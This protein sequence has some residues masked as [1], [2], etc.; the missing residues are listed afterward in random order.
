MNLF[1]HHLKHPLI[2]A[3]IV[4]HIGWRHEP[5]QLMGISHFLEHVHYLGSKHYPDIDA[6]T[7]R[8]GTEINGPTLPESTAFSF[9]VL[10]EDFFYVLPVLLDIVYFPRFDSESIERERNIVDVPGNPSDYMAWEWVRLK[11]DDMVFNTNELHSLGTEK[12]IQAIQREDLVKWQNDFYHTGN[13]HLL[14]A[15]DVET[16]EVQ[17]LLTKVQLPSSGKRPKIVKYEHQKQH[18]QE[19]RS[20]IQPEMYIGFRFLPVRN[21]LPYKL[22]EI[23]L[24]NYGNSVLFRVLRQETPLAYMVESRVRVLS[25]VVRF[26]IYAGVAK[27]GNEKAVWELL[28]DLLARIKSDGFSDVEL[29]WAKRVFR[30]QLMKYA[31]DPER[32]ISFRLKWNNWEEKFPGFVALAKELEDITQE[33]LQRLCSELFRPEKCFISVVGPSENLDLEGWKGELR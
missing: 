14:I 32:A 25:D 28:S 12:T 3:S 31:S 18:Y 2:A 6:E 27:E 1:C 13:S 23:L 15:G 33:K 22:L 16:D 26:G 8:F 17:E 9:T 20:N 7:A 19:L 4:V 11:T 29:R 30:L 21:L 5:S 10:K 24:G